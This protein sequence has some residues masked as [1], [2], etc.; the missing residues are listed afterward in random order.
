MRAPVGRLKEIVGDIIEAVDRELS[1]DDL[2]AIHFA[3]TGI[4]K[5]LRLRGQAGPFY[6]IG[7]RM[8]MACAMLRRR[9]NS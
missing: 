9:S 1:P 2:G 4:I 5:G 7:L 6:G 8:L 3:I